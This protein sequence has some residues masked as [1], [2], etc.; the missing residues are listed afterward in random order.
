[1]LLRGSSSMS[2]MV[3]AV[4]IM[5]RLVPAMT[6]IICA[7]VWMPSAKWPWPVTTKLI[8]LVAYLNL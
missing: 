4:T 8:I 1:M 2:S 3:T 7:E 6:A 5:G